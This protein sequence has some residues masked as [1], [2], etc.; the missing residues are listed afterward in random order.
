M[1]ANG[2]LRQLGA[3]AVELMPAAPDKPTWSL[4]ALAAALERRELAECEAAA[5]RLK[6][7]RVREINPSLVK[8]IERTTQ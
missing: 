1:R 5:L 8:H 7:A 3:G 6:L 4:I 2:C